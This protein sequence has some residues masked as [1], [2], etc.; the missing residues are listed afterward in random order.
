[1]KIQITG[2]PGS[3]KSTVIKAFDV[4]KLDLAEYKGARR[5]IRFQEDAKA[6]PS[7]VFIESACGIDLRGSIVVQLHEPI[8]TVQSRFRD[9][10][11]YELSDSLIAL[12]EPI[13]VPW[14][15]KAHGQ[16]ALKEILRKLTK[17]NRT[18]T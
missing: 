16:Q 9:R 17:E 6:H 5:E 12:Y 13:M 18:A 7:P 15:Y 8:K 3:G 2:L 11:N 10:D 4:P 14:H 1:M